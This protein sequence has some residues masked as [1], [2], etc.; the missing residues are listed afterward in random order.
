[1]MPVVRLAGLAALLALLAP[2]LAAFFA[3]RLPVG[4]PCFPVFAALLAPLLAFFAA[5]LL[6]TDIAAGLRVGAG[7]DAQAEQKGR[8]LGDGRHGW[9][10]QSFDVCARRRILGKLP[11]L[12]LRRYQPRRVF[13]SCQVRRSSQV[14]AVVGIFELVEPTIM[15]EPPA[16]VGPVQS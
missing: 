11:G 8:D 7:A 9:L 4:T 3:V 1:M 12:L 2:F 15:S 6:S 16:G 10:P 5:L 13:I 14:S